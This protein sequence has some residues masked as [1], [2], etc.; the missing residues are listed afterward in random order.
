[1]NKKGTVLIVTALALVT[2]GVPG[3][4]DGPITIAADNGATVTQTSDTTA[5][6]TLV[7]DGDTNI[8]GTATA[9]GTPISGAMVESAAEAA[10]FILLTATVKPDA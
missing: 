7:N 8:T 6:V 2:A 4:V 5:E 9:A 3:F 10:T 1:M